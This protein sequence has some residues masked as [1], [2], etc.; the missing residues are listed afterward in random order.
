MKP[1]SYIIN[2]KTVV[3]VYDKIEYDKW[4]ELG[5]K[6]GTVGAILAKN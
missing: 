6:L 1:I 2:D 5:E 4:K 3:F